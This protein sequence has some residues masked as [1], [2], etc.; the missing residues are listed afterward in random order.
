M[1]LQQAAARDSM[2]GAYIG[3][4]V[5]GMGLW[6]KNKAGI[7]VH[8]KR[9][10]KPGIVEPYEYYS[11]AQIEY[12]ANRRLQ[13]EAK[14]Q[15]KA[16][17]TGIEHSWTDSISEAAAEVRAAGHGP[18]PG[19][20]AFMDLAK[21]IHQQYVDVGK[22]LPLNPNPKEYPKK[23]K[24]S[25]MPAPA[26]YFQIPPAD[27]ARI[28]QETAPQARYNPALFRK[29]TKKQREMMAMQQEMLRALEQ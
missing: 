7:R 26:Q 1:I 5:E 13:R 14:K 21:R 23:K 6:H 16:Q 8:A 28:Y 4:G 9:H 19:T 20:K 27:L 24:T 10:L 3:A 11:A 2:G 17:Q 22:A 18:R 15:L 29:P 25:G 12:D